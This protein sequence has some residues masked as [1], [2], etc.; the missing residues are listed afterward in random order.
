MQIFETLRQESLLGQ[1]IE[2]RAKL[3]PNKTAI[4]FKNYELSYKEVNDKVNALATSLIK[5]SVTHQDRIAIILPT[6]P[7]FIF[8]WLA[9]AKIGATIVGLNVRYR[10]NEL[11]YMINS[12]KPSMVVCINEFAG[13]NYSEFLG[14]LAPKLPS[15]KHFIFIG[16][17]NFPG[18]MN[19]EELLNQPANLS[20]LAEA[21]KNVNS[22]SD[23]F[24]IFT[25]GSTG[26]PKGAVLTQKSIMAMVKPWVNNIKLNVDDKML[27]VLPL[28]HVGGGTIIAISCLATGATLV[29]HDIFKPDEVLELIKKHRVTVMGGVPTIYATFFTLPNFNNDYLSSLRLVIYGGAAASPELLQK[30]TKYMNRVTI[31]GCYGATELSGF[32]TYTSIN[33][34]FEKVLNTVGRT[35]AEFAIK[36]V[37]PEDRKELSI[38][39]IGE[40]AIKGDLVFDRYLDMPD[41]TKKVIDDEGWFYTGD[42][43]FLDQDGYVTLVG[44]Y[45]EMYI[46]SGFNVYPKEIEDVL[47]E[48]PDVAI[49]AVIGMPDEIKGE[50]GWA[51]VMKKPGTSVTEDELKAFCESKV[52]KYKVPSRIFVEDNLPATPLGKIHKPTL[53]ELAV[54]RLK[55][56]P[57]K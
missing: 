46:T 50:V 37:N 43:G 11:L 8:V 44:R 39:K 26:R 29:L 5:M 7:E 19:F 17:S 53:K 35:P 6:R 42:M 54:E 49:S 48:H 4:I 40:V 28:N 18:A 15:V 22:E 33:D 34:D 1:M 2:N 51:F 20:L 23:N 10:E 16:K 24:I 25:S 12:T 56:T 31:M 57:G 38:G 47:M 41:E 30:M 27:D 13:V 14:T 3:I 9:A 36:I 45:K 55:I 21:A 52:A 32:C